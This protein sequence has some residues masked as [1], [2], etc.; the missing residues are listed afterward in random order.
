ETLLRQ[1]LESSRRQFGE[2]GRLTLR[3]LHSLGQLYLSM[4]RHSAAD[5]LLR[6]VL[7]AAQE[8][9]EVAPGDQ[10]AVLSTLG[11][12]ARVAGQWA[13]AER[14]QREAYVLGQTALRREGLQFAS[15]AHNF[16]QA[17]TSLGRHTEA[18]RLYQ[19]ALRVIRKQAGEAHPN[20][21][22]TA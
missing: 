15:V 9:G 12:I 18:E 6:R 7:T 3:C 5:A 20:Y 2:R 21:A 19:E 10:V 16:A 13:E 11:G 4:G 14:F 8:G 1:V 17:L 22:T